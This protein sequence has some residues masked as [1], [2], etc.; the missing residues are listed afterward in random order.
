MALMSAYHLVTFL[1]LHAGRRLKGMRRH[2]SLFMQPSCFHF[3]SYRGYVR[4]GLLSHLQKTCTSKGS[5]V[6]DRIRFVSSV[7]VHLFGL[8]QSSVICIHTH[9]KG[10]NHTQVKVG[11]RLAGVRDHY[12]CKGHIVQCHMTHKMKPEK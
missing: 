3:M 6:W 5:I 1:A 10:S 7:S 8:N 2:I 11:S 4:H 9:L 12:G